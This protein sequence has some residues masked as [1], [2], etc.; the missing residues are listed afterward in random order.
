MYSLRLLLLT[1]VHVHIHA[2]GANGSAEISYAKR[3]TGDCLKSVS[4]NFHTLYGKRC[5]R[6][7]MY[8]HAGNYDLT[9]ANE[10]LKCKLSA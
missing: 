7:Y 5:I 6:I 9:Y 4:S 1:D 8:F 10:A 3:N 2:R